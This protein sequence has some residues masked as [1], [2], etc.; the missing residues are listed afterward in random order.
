M[1]RL[2]A[3]VAAEVRGLDMAAH[4]SPRQLPMLDRT[5]QLALIAARQAMAAGGAAQG[6]T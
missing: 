5:S 4:F 3:K 1:E 6:G 2:N